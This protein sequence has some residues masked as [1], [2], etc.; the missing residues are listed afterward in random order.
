MPFL[1]DVWCSS[2]THVWE[3]L[4]MSPDEEVGGC[5]ECGSFNTERV[6]G[7]NLARCNDPAVRAEVLKQRSL[8]H[9]R[10]HAKE[11]VERA[12]AKINRR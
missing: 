4:L 8:D 10:A 6:M 3:V 9:S 2:C 1:T 7:G 12:L 5:P 11:N